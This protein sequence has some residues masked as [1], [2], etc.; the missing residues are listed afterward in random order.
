MAAGADG[1]GAC[2]KG[3]VAEDR[4]VY[5]RAG[6]GDEAGRAADCASVMR[7][8]VANDTGGVPMMSTKCQDE[9]GVLHSW[10]DREYS[11]QWQGTSDGAT[12]PADWRTEVVHP[13]GS[14]YPAVSGEP[15][16]SDAGNVARPCKS[17]F[18]FNEDP[19]ASSVR[20][21]CDA[22]PSLGEAQLRRVTYYVRRRPCGAEPEAAFLQLPAA[23]LCVAAL[24]A[25]VFAIF[26][27]TATLPATTGSSAVAVAAIATATV[28]SARSC[29]LCLV[30][31]LLQ[32]SGVQAQGPY[33]YGPAQASLYCWANWD[34]A[35]FPVRSFKSLDACKTACGDAGQACLAIVHGTYNGEG[36]ETCVLCTSS[37]MAAS[38]GA[39]WATAY[40][41]IYPPAPPP[42][43]PPGQNAPGR[44]S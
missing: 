26:V 23:A 31:V 32:A 36:A 41:K 12:P 7:P 14:A 19:S 9:H 11:V 16:A 3:W 29:R 42:S 8:W 25:A 10:V 43:S 28:A 13:Q 38:A 17:A 5:P 20:T 37:G 6:W 15:F 27:A 44:A 39:S 2:R 18:S 30:L 4:C 33:G 40:L 24:V 22:R 35:D 21:G 1:L 34:A